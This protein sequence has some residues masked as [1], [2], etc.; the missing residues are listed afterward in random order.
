M[1]NV[2]KIKNSTTNH[3][4]PTS[5]VQGEFAVNVSTGGR[6]RHKVWVGNASSAVNEIGYIAQQTDTAAQNTIQ[7]SGTNNVVGLTIKLGSSQTA[8][9]TNWNNS[10][11]DTIAWV[12]AS[13]KI[14]AVG[15]DASS[16]KIT[17]V[18]DP[19]SA[20]DAATKNYVDGFIPK[21]TVTTAGDLI[22]G[23]G[24]ATV[25]RLGIG[26]NGQVL[27]VSSGA[28]AWATPSSGVTDHGLLTGL[29]D[30]DHTQYLIKTPTTST[31]NAISLTSD[32]VA[33]RITGASG[34]TANLLEIYDPTSVLQTYVDGDGDVTVKSLVVS[35]NLTVNGTTTNIN[36]TSLVVEDKNI[37][38]AD[39]TTPT[40]TTA[41]GGGITL[42]GATDKTFNWVDSTDSWTSSEHMDLASA[43]IYKIAGTSVLSATTL[44]SGVTSSSLTSVGTIGTG[45]WQGTLIGSTYGGTGVNN[46]GRT[47]TVGGNLSTSCA[48]T[49]S[50]NTTGSLTFTMSTG[51]TPS[52][53]IPNTTATMLVDNSTID[54]GTY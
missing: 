12:N 35:G 33:L 18:L 4:V 52:I 7:V 16:Q 3:T 17:S 9:L 46:A 1:A 37:I 39:V 30:D 54:G 10:V 13:G 15:F 53:T 48:F 11:D 29:A 6:T 40:D 45:T 51:N 8:N 43:K 19:T 14:T 27:T 42:K 20:Q 36:S 26:S 25:S 47:L 38:L 21:S 49:I 24:S 41:D 28:L 50:G 23:T 2:I 44:G 5:L 32:V 34:Q 31:R 22:Y